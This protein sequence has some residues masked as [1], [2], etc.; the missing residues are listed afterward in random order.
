[1]PRSSVN[2][3][4]GRIL[5]RATP[6]RSGTRHSISV[7]RRS[8]SHCSSSL[9]VNLSRTTIDHPRIRDAAR[10]AMIGRLDRSRYDLQAAPKASN[11]RTTPDC[12][13]LPFGMPLH[14]QIEAPCAAASRTLRPA[15]RGAR[16]DAQAPAPS[17]SPPG[18]HRIHFDR[19][20]PDDRIKHAARLN[21]DR[22]AQ[23]YC[24]IGARVG[25]RAVVVMPGY[26]V[27][28]LVQRAAQRHVRF[29][30]AAADREQRDA[31]LDAPSESAAASMHRARHPINAGS[32]TSSPKWLGCTLDGDPVSSTPCARSSTASISSARGRGTTSGRPPARRT[33]S[34]YFLPATW[35]GCSPSMRL[36]AGT[37]TT[38]GA[39]DAGAATTGSGRR[40]SASTAC[41]RSDRCAT[42]R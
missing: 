27:H 39:R 6:V 1:M 37:R 12:R 42:F 7:T 30:E 15:R 10:A 31:A 13:G 26:L 38:A 40:F 5:P 41:R 8:S 21:V 14:A 28:R 20:L 19:R 33:A 34:M 22:C 35:N 36:H 32:C 4:R 29:L 17:G 11:N 23:A 9:N 18:V 2:F 24:F 3:S 25:W 16:L